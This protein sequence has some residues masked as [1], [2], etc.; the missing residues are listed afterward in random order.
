MERVN[1][2]KNKEKAG[3][4]EMQRRMLVAF[5]VMLILIVALTMRVGWIQV[6]ANDKYMTRAA[7]GRIK[8]E[9]VAPDRGRILDRN[10]REFAV[11]STKYDIWIRIELYPSEANKEDGWLEG[12]IDLAVRAVAR[13]AGKGEDELRALLENGTTRVR[14]VRNTDKEHMLAISAAAKELTE[15]G[16]VAVLETVE[17]DSRSY[18]LG[19][20]ASNVIGTVNGDGTGQSGV[21]LSYNNYLSGVTGRSIV[22]TD[23]NGNKVSGGELAN[24]E[25]TDGL[26]VILT[27]DETIQYY[28]EQALAESMAATESDRMIAIVMDPKTGDILA[29]GTTDNYDP[30]NPQTPLTEEGQ[31][32]L[33]A[34][35][36]DAKSE[37]LSNMWK[38]PL[39]S[40]VYDPG[41]V[42]KLVTV[43][44]A[45]EVGSAKP[46]EDHYYCSGGIDV[47][48]RFI[49]CWDYPKSH[50]NQTIAEAVKNSCNPAMI[51]IVQKMGFENYYR[52][53]E[54]FG[55]TESTGVKL[56]G[57][58]EPLIQTNP[59]P[60]GLA[61]MSFGQGLS[62]T[63]LQMITA[64]SAIAN[65]GKLMEPRIAVGLADSDGNVVEKFP[66]KI[67]RQVLSEA[68][69]AEVRSIM[70]YVATSDGSQSRS[71]HIDGYNIGIKTGT[72]QKLVGDTYESGQVIGSMVLVAPIEDPKFVVLVIADNPKTTKYGIAAAG[73]ATNKIATETLRYLNVKPTYTE[74]ELQSI[75]S[76][77]KAVPDVTGKLY[78]EAAIIL[79]NAGF[80]A[81]AQNGGAE[82][83]YQV[84]DQYPKPGSKAIVGGTVFL[85]RS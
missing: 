11:S 36:E 59:G 48:D 70:E 57:E 17:N 28:L 63:P 33:A 6:V 24:Y 23:G 49:R 55:I 58:A 13:G 21:E 54:L 38:N 10:G 1:K 61:T 53:L 32:A 82:E 40:D 50:G 73:P 30:N 27:I 20:L 76:R 80:K 51:Q 31:A 45:I 4:P 67:K 7:D 74:E 43:S 12:Q 22:N 52:Y 65:D 14:V 60:V 16:S 39:V 47:Y 72:T 3:L 68:T 34:L 41:S 8:D 75:A 15:G 69:A 81:N 19:T 56:P 29:M 44:S 18:P 85:Y 78:S 66:T 26:S 25:S 2:R 46:E 42:F 62:I 37:Y 71:G 79:D 9:V 64:V 83:D 35:E 5:A 77:E 84:I